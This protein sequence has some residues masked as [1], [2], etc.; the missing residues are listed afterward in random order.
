MLLDMIDGARKTQQ[1]RYTAV[2]ARPQAAPLA[3]A[4]ISVGK[5]L[6]WVIG[7]YVRFRYH[8]TR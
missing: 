1:R 4:G 5:A 2:C 8:D 7:K 6:S 3:A